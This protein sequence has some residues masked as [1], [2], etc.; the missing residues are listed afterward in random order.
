MKLLY[1]GC[2]APLEYYE[3]KLFTELGIDCFSYQGA[4]ADPRGHKSL[5]R[6]AIEGMTYHPELEELARQHPKTAIPDEIIEQF[7][8]IMI[9]HTPQW[10]T[11]NWPK[12]KHKKVVWRSIGQ[13]TRHV[14]NMIRRMRYE[15]MKIVR[16]SPMEENI[17]DYLGSDALI[18][19][20]QDENE[21]KDWNGKEKR[22]INFTQSLMG[23]RNFCHYDEIMAIMDGFP[24]LIFGTANDDLGPLNGGELPYE[25]MKGQLRDNR[26][27]VYGG[28]WP[29]CYTL[30]FQ[31][32]F[33][34]GIPIVAIGP[35]L[36][37]EIPSIPPAERIKFYEIPNF[38]TDGQNGFISDD[39][40]TLRNNVHKLLEDYEFAA[41]MGQAGRS[42]AIQLFG[43][44]KVKTDWKV[45]LNSL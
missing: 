36:A 1:L 11:E 16:Y 30:M 14:E 4:Y 24:A 26:V 17:P 3:L 2:H 10:I 31:E 12:M 42:T 9:M 25:L 23:R 32:A 34:T 39:M 29:A 5:P 41:K 15:G 33:M 7:D 45:F 20:Y 21:Y 40:A 13:S 8:V 38:I 6:P 37:Q 18:R 22:V 43:K 35:K 27:F 44:E 19:F 28:T